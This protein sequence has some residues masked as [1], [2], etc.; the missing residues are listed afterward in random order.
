MSL[1]RDETL[2]ELTMPMVSVCICT[3]RRPHRLARLLRAIEQQDTAGRFTLQ[4]VVVDNDPQRSARVALH[5]FGRRTLWPFESAWVSEPNIAKARNR[6]VQ[7]AQG[8]FLALIDDDE[9]PAPDWLLRHF[10]V[11][12]QTQAQGVLGPVLPRY[13]S[14]PPRWILHGRFCERPRHAT[15]QRL[16]EPKLMRTGNVLLRR[17]CLQGEAG[18]FDVRLGR[19]GGEDVDFFRRRLARGDTFVW[20][21]EAAVFESVPSQRM[22][23]SYFLKRAWLRGTVN[24]ERASLL[25]WSTA[26]S[27]AA[28]TIYSF[29]LPVLGLWRHDI[30]MQLLMRDCDHLGKIFARCGVKLI[31]QRQD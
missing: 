15:G 22:T 28:A 29:L 19:T 17:E 10:E 18:P 26:K 14:P 25:S 27:V 20:C 12:E 4:L 21:D 23:R 11:L 5:A 7:L 24:A 8:P 13:E 31:R 1:T 6:A 9:V 3:Y 16:G 2:N 30:F